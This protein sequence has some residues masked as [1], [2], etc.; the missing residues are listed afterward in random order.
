MRHPE[1]LTA[2]PSLAEEIFGEEMGGALGY[3]RLL[4]TTGVDHGLIGPREVPRLWER[5]ILNCAVLEE[6]L[7]PEAVVGDIGSGAGLP[8]LAVAIARP[9]VE[10]HLIEPLA[11]RTVW[12]EGA[13][14]ELDLANVSVHR[15]R[16]ESFAGELSCDVV[17]ARAV[18]R[19]ERL[20]EW[21]GPLLK[22]G[23]EL[24]ALKGSSADQELEDD[25]DAI[26]RA[27]GVEPRIEVLGAGRLEVPTTIVRIRFPSGASRRPVASGK[28]K[29]AAAR[30]GSGPRPARGGA[31]GRGG[32]GNA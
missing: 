23:G 13:I 25:L 26:R 32:S 7:P 27:G 17:T 8:G 30:R 3:A 16:A 9:D 19:L 10:V 24:I 4:A 11:R 28:G 22:P 12:L 20:A 5:H 15:G 2:P 6:V 18:A 1:D 14:A 31:G 29:R 21:A